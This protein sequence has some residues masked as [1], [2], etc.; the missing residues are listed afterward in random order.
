[1]GNEIQRFTAAK[2]ELFDRIYGRLNPEQREAIYTVNGPLLVLAGAG[3]GKTTVLVNRISHMI[4]YGDAYYRNGT[5]KPSDLDIEMLT[6][7]NKFASDEDAEMILS[8]YAVDP[9]K[10]YGILAITFTNKA[11]DEIKN[12]LAESLNDESISSQIWAGTFHSICVRILRRHLD[13]LGFQS[14]SLTIYDTEDTK[15]LI[16]DILKSLNI[17]DKMLPVRTVMTEISRAKDNLVS[18]DDFS[19]NTGNDYR[20]SQISKVYIRYQSEL[21]KANAMD[22]DDLIMRTVMLLKDNKDVLD[23]YQSKFRYIC[24][25]E[26]QDTNMAQFALIE[27][28]SGKYRNIMV[29]GDDD[30]SIYKFRGATIKNILEFDTVFSAC[31]LIKLEQNYR[32]TQTILNAANS[33]IKNNFG[34]KGK[35]LWTE[36]Q[37]GE[38]IVLEELEDQN[39]ESRYIVDTISEYVKSGTK[40]YKDFA[41]LYRLNAQANNIESAFARSGMP[42]R[43]FG[44]IRFYDRKEIR[45]ILAYLY[46]IKNPGDNLHLKRIIN[47]PKR[48]IG[49]STINAVEQLSACENKSM[50]EI[51]EKADTYVS[52]I[53]SAEKLISFVKMINRFRELSESISLTELIETV[54]EETGY[55]EML[56][57]EGS[58]GYERQQNIDE[59]SSSAIEYM[60]K[61]VS[62]EEKPLDGFLESISLVSDIDKYD[63]SA[64]AVNLMTIHSAKGLEF[65]IVFLPGM[66]EY[67]FPSSQSQIDDEQMEEER[68]LAYVAVTRAK[69]KLYILHSS[70]R[71]LYGR[72]QNN[73]LSRFAEEIPKELIQSSIPVKGKRLRENFEFRKTSRE[74]ENNYIIDEFEKNKVRQNYSINNKTNKARINSNQ[75]VFKIGDRVK[76]IKFGSGVILSATQLVGDTIYEIAFDD[77]GTKKLMASYAKLTRE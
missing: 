29:V 19:A 9:V 38:K 43:V 5:V 22:F 66:E 57:E 54:V 20:L 31:K 70:E 39:E 2:R 33:I 63:E 35:N 50:M 34:R 4:K 72:T 23:Y 11:A 44:S 47:T 17:D 16:G 7:A 13:L 10:A 46:L 65:P 48:K 56:E 40:T 67:V 68:R 25:D 51:M 73:E 15:K 26:Y 62:E 77:V 61:Y 75:T 8:A 49:N 58:I 32:S 14:G 55:R 74:S 28:L 30:Q 21:Q 71:L 24:V 76:H 59:L 6:E 52:I 64:D 36:K 53:K 12:R 45:D 18:P 60:E 37:A 3:S 69:E 42:Y 1:M 27:L 41:V